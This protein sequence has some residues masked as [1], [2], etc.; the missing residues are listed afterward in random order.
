MPWAWA[1]EQPE[2]APRLP[3]LTLE[4]ETQLDLATQNL[5]ARPHLLTFQRRVLRAAGFLSVAQVQQVK[6]GRRACL[7][8]LV[9]SAQRPPTAKGM[10][11][12]VLEDET[13]RVQVAL[14]PKIAETLR[15]ALA[16]SR[17]LAVGGK[18]ERAAGHVTLLAS[19][20]EPYSASGGASDNGV[21]S[22]RREGRDGLPATHR[23]DERGSAGAMGV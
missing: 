14:P 18:V 1:D 2:E 16:E 4:Q 22:G 5:S 17:I 9:I 10:G 21:S 23:S 13:G 7:A 6:A 8:G 20:I 11:F 3:P 15:P 19:R 12:I